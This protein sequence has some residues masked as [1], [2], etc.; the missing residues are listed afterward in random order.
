MTFIVYF[1]ATVTTVEYMQDNITT[2]YPPFLV[3]V[4]D[5]KYLIDNAG[6]Y[7]LI[8]PPGEVTVFPGTK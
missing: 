6:P 3:N 1:E 5:P 2:I 4:K 8:P 7:F